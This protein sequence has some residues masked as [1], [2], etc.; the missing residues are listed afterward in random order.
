MYLTS[1]ATMALMLSLARV[2]EHPTDD[3]SRDRAEQRSDRFAA[4]EKV[5]LL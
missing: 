2:C 3:L 5:M 4:G 1:V